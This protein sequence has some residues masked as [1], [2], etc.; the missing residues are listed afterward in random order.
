M[1]SLSITYSSFTPNTTIS[2]SQ[3]NTNNSDITTWVNNR[4]SAAADWDAFSCAAQLV[5]KP[6]TNQLVLGTTRTVTITAP[7]P[8]S[9]SRTWTIPDRTGDMTFMAL[10]ATQTATGTT[11]FVDGGL[12]LRGSDAAFS[13]T[14]RTAAFAAARQYTIPDA[15]GA[16]SFVMTAGT[17]T[18]TGTI[19]FSG[20]LIGKGTATNDS[21]AAGYIGEYTSGTQAVATN[22]P[23]TTEFGDGTSI[24]LTAGDWDVSA[25]LD[26]ILNGATATSVTLGISTTTGNSTAGL[27]FGNNM[28]SSEA[29]TATNNVGLSIP[30]HRVSLSATTTVYLKVSSTYGAGNPQYKCRL[31]A[32][33]VR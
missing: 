14:L 1:A 33:R 13:A 22:F 24:S 3:V 28:I 27:T 4:N 10:E 20:Q 11:T 26:G 16:A 30:G 17:Q 5:V 21:A 2:S 31:S 19:T 9:S 8:A 6:T 25:V 32:R 18:L 7:T 23:T 29:P 12:L 15:G